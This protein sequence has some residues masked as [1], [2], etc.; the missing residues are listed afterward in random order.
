MHD[1]WSDV[2]FIFQEASERDGVARERTPT[3]AARLAQCAAD[4]GAS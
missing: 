3:L 2:R 1:H 4:G